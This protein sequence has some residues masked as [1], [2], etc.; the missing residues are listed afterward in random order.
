MHFAGHT[1]ATDRSFV[2]F[3][4]PVSG[5]P[6]FPR[7]S[8]ATPERH[9][10]RNMRASII[11]KTLFLAVAAGAAYAQ[12]GPNPQRGHDLAARVCRACHVIDRETPGPMQAEAPSFAV[13]ARQPW[14][15]AEYVAARITHPHPQ[16]P[17]FPLT[18]Q[19]VRD[20]AAYI[21]TLKR[22]D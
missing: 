19:E 7:S 6:V 3:E 10:G 20:L 13:I 16:M 2:E 9:L 8:H 21:V 15:G 22:D 4:W 17:G 14:V 1:A 18:T 12:P 5:N 11:S